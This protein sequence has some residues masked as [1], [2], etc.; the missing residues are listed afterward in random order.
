[1]SSQAPERTGAQLVAGIREFAPQLWQRLPAT[2]R[3]R[4]ASHLRPY[5]DV[6]R[7]RLPA[8]TAA[9]LH[10]L[11]QDGQLQVH[12]GRILGL[13]LAGKQVQV[14][15]RPRGARAPAT[16]LVDRVINCTGPNYD[17]TQ[18]RERLLRGLLAQGVA[19]ADPLRLGLVTDSLGRLIGAQGEPARNL[20]YLGPLLRARDWESTAASELRVHALA[21]ARHLRAPRRGALDCDPTAPGAPAPLTLPRVN[22]SAKLQAS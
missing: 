15:Y 22:H 13:E 21:L 5:W 3:R 11:Q 9:A 4:F 8:S 1:M 12:A 10:G 6:H 19:V 2:A 18:T 16:L 20:Y 14:R 7:H 17:I